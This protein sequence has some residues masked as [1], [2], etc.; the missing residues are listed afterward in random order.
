MTLTGIRSD[1][2][3]VT[4]AR[5]LRGRAPAITLWAVQAILAISFVAAGSQKLAG[6]HYMVIMFTKIGAGQWLRYAIGFL[7]V[8][9]LIVSRRW[10][11]VKTMARTR[12]VTATGRTA[13]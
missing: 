10:Q 12:T 2:A 8:S 9:A 3:S 13:R 4:A 6:T 7:A 5:G 11:Q 1:A